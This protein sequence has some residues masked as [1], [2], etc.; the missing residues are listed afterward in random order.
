[1]DRVKCAYENLD[2]E[3]E[4]LLNENY[5]IQFRKNNIKCEGFFLPFSFKKFAEAIRK[6]EVRDDDIWV[7]SFPKAGTTWVQEMVWCL[8]NGKHHEDIRKP[9]NDRFQFL[10]FSAILDFTT[11]KGLPENSIGDI[12]KLASPRYI[13]THLPFNLLPEKLQNFSTNAKVIHVMRNSRD[14]LISYYHHH[15]LFH[16]YKGSFPQFVELF[17]KGLVYYGP[18]PVHLKGYLALEKNPKILFL[19]YEEMQKDLK[20][21]IRKTSNF[22]DKSISESE[23]E[24]LLDHLSFSSMKNNPAVNYTKNLEE[25]KQLKL[26]DD[27][28]CDFQWILFSGGVVKQKQILT[29]RGASGNILACVYASGTGTVKTNFNG[30]CY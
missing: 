17:F 25:R 5:T 7:C 24:T 30:E 4:Q 23:T 22:I 2:T 20:S 10:E 1:M 8:A 21:V 27:T 26:V 15:K 28:A 16:D 13:K 18:F 6:M 29:C 12:E 11:V 9:I 14:T 19:K 3:S